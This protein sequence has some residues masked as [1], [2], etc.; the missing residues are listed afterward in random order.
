MAY[1]ASEETFDDQ[2]D[3]LNDG[4][5]LGAGLGQRRGR[6][7]HEPA[8]WAGTAFLV[9]ALILLAFLAASLGIL[10]TV[11]AESQDQAVQAQRLETAVTLA[12]DAAE[13]FAA[14]P[15][16][17]PALQTCERDGVEYEVACQAQVDP[18]QPAYRSASITVTSQDEELFV[19]Q[20]GRAVEDGER[21]G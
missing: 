1:M 15:T 19:L 6:H 12:S 14:D 7:A 10:A 3:A 13:S 2:R 18:Q 11:F 8:A 9:E 5:G 17:V 16:S 20:T 21:H 4:L